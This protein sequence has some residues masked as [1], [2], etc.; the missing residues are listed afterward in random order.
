[1]GVEGTDAGADMGAGAGGGA[2]A[3]AP[4]GKA[5]QMP[6][7]SKALATVSKITSI[8]GGSRKFR[9]ETQNPSALPVD[10]RPFRRA[11]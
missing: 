8:A 2:S 7:A 6:S 1:M 5:F 3:A 4:V 9:G 10:A 11:S